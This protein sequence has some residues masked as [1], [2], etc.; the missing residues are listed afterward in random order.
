[1]SF[2]YEFNKPEKFRFNNT[3]DSIKF[4]IDNY[5]SLIQIFRV[6]QAQMEETK[7]K[8]EKA[9][10]ELQNLRDKLEKISKNKIQLS[11]QERQYIEELREFYTKIREEDDIIYF[12]GSPLTL[13]E[14]TVI[15]IK[16]QEVFKLFEFVDR[17]ARIQ[18]AKMAKSTSK[19]ILNPIHRILKKSSKGKKTRL[20]S[21][22]KFASK[23]VEN[24]PGC[25]EEEILNKTKVN[26]DDH[27]PIV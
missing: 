19:T 18:V 7:I 20:K 27:R 23:V 14:A 13:D 21:A 6:M 22:L 17:K 8:K 10:E 24:F 15:L 25:L 5:G 1:M 2:S 4:L 11:E 9:N 16:Y 3:E 26:L 12:N